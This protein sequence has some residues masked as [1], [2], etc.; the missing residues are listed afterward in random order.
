MLFGFLPSDFFRIS[1]LGFRIGAPLLL[2]A[3]L[4]APSR[5]APS[6][7][8]EPAAPETPREFFNAG[9][10]RL[11]EKKLREAESLLE[12]TL[13]SQTEALQPPALYNLGHVRFSQ[14]LEQLKKG[15]AAGPTASAGRVTS[16]A[17]DQ[18]IRVADDALAGDDMQKLIS[19]Y[20]NGYGARKDLRSAR[21]AVRRALEVF[22]GALKKWQRASGDFKSVVELKPNDTDARQNADTVDRYIAKLID[23]IRELEQMMG[24]MGEKNRELSQKLQQLRG[25][26]PAPDMPP[27]APGDDEEDEDSPEGQP[28]GQQE[29][30]SREGQ[31]IKLSREQAGW[32]L[33]SFRLDR[34]R[35]LPMGQDQQGE[36]L[37]KPKKPW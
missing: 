6:T 29:G 32:L 10:R 26:I 7:N 4:A 18:A 5:A 28:P 25:R 30:P 36:P 20:I 19:A 35:R 17:A 37:G 34:E 23:T 31:E 16:D 12:A 1:D 21:K 15:P 22:G 11:E 8:A 33:D 2:L 27:G 24:N 13:S 3:W 9:T 14:G